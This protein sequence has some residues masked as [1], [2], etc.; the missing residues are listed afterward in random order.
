M[1][2]DA[3]EAALAESQGEP[4]LVTLAAGNVNTGAFDPVA[5]VVEAAHAVGAW[6][7]VDGAFGLWAA[8]SPALRHLTRGVA[9]ADSWATDA[10][11]W[12]NV[13][14]DCGLAMTRHPASH[15]AALGVKAAYLI[16]SDG[17]PDPVELVPEFSRRARGVPV[18]AAL[19]SLGR[20]GVA[21][22]VERCCAMAR[23]FETALAGVEGAEVLNEVVLNQVLVRFDDDDAVTAAVSAAV[24]ADGSAYMGPTTFKGRGAMR[25]SVSGWQTDER[26]VDHSVE[27]VRRGLA[28]ARLRVA[29]GR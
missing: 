11:K 25:I 7:H 26:D 22:L 24:R 6:V 4:T 29:A 21:D 20:Q 28:S 13:P 16:G 5:E 1:R 2:P 8:A 15:R 23:R 14:Y 10:H 9:G 18:Y 19:R 3:L 27:A 12:L 17:P